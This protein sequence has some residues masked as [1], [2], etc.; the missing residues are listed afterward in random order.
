MSHR[1][2][3]TCG[4]LMDNEI[5]LRQAICHAL[6]GEAILFLGAG[7]AKDATTDKGDSLPAG[8]ELA[9]YLAAK[10]GLQK[11]YL[12]DTTGQ[13]QVLRLNKSSIERNR[14]SVRCG[15]ITVMNPPMGL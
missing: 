1:N 5:T 8:Q 9:D 3:T 10:C 2:I 6:D 4:D 11:G 14:Y 15:V 12:L 7:A 13:C